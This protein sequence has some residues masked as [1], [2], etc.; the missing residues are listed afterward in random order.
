MYQDCMAIVQKFG[1]PTLFIT[2][3]CNPEWREIQEAFNPGET[4]F[5]RPDICTRVFKLK[6]DELLDVIE[7]KE[8]FGKV[9]AFVGTI[10][11]QKRKGLHH[12]HNLIILESEYVPKNPG[13]IDKIVC[14]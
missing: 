6:N 1:K 4:A 8:I 5:D 13:D 3:T 11:Q 9:K 7:K 14:A 2:M 10:E 12:S